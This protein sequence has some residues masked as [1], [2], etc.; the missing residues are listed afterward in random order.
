MSCA[1]GPGR[2]NSGVVVVTLLLGG[3]MVG[4]NYKGPPPEITVDLPQKFKNQP[5]NSR[6]R[7]ARPNDAAVGGT[8]WRWFGD[9]ELT[10]LVETGLA[11][12]T[13]LQQQVERVEQARA[14]TRLAAAELKPNLTE[15]ASFIRQRSTSTGAEQR[16]RT[17][18]SLSALTGGGGT[19]GPQ[20]V[21]T[22]SNGPLLTSQPVFT[23]AYDF[24]TPIDLSWELDLFG[25]VRRNIE[26]ARAQRQAAE[27]D[28]EALRLSVTANIAVNYFSLRA[29]DAQLDVLRQ[30]S[31]CLPGRRECFGRSAQLGPASRS[32]GGSDHRGSTLSATDSTAVRQRSNYVFGCARC[33]ANPAQ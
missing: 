33:R 6:F 16:A 28:L 29:L 23:T 10:R 9:R 26:S 17:V 14:Q 8:W 7:P 3:C 4:P 32:A 19:G 2:W 30:T 1:S 24:R 18:G 21:F 13:D 12:S 27:A 5:V 22:G 20:P 11:G 25:R 31:D 15:D